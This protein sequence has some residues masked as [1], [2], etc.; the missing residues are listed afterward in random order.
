MASLRCYGPFP[1]VKKLKGA[2]KAELPESIAPQL[3][4]LVQ[5]A[6]SGDDWLHEI[7]VDGYRIIAFLERS[8]VR[9]QSR[10]GLDWTAKFPRIARRI[11]TLLPVKSAVLDGEVVALDENGASNFGAL[12]QALSGGRTD[13]LVYYAFDL[14]Y[15]DGYDITDARLEDRKAVL[16]PLLGGAA[17]GVIRYSDHQ[18][19]RGPEFYNSACS[20][21]LEGVVSKRRGPS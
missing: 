19:G 17:E 7:K 18:P 12:Q 6:P 3:A 13:D 2:R 20:L 1:D 11:T 14:L 5:A 15:L 8:N 21:A 9:L 10:N 16:K 4:T